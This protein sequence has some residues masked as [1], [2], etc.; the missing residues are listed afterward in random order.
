MREEPHLQT[1]AAVVVLG[2]IEDVMNLAGVPGDPQEVA[3]TGWTAARR[4]ARAPRWARI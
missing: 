3:P 1:I 4:M 2:I